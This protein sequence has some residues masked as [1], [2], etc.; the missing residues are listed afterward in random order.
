MV[1]CSPRPFAWAPDHSGGSSAAASMGMNPPL[2]PRTEFSPIT[3]NDPHL[4]APLCASAFASYNSLFPGPG[5]KSSRPPFQTIPV[6]GAGSAAAYTP[7][8][9]RSSK[10]DPAIPCSTGRSGDGR[11][12]NPVVNS[13]KAIGGGVYA[14]E[15]PGVE[16]GDLIEVMDVAG[17]VQGMVPLGPGL[18]WLLRRRRIGRLT[19]QRQTISR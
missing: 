1:S 18:F 14:P 7:Y 16:E 11:S 2:S 10:P 5:S 8:P 15:T 19:Q 3:A 17:E 4:P 6:R 9:P 12:R 13:A